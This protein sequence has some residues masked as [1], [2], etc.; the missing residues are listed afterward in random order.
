[1]CGD[2]VVNKT[3]DY[4]SEIENKIDELHKLYTDVSITNI[5]NLL[6]VINNLIF[7]SLNIPNSKPSIYL[8]IA[9]LL[10]SPIGIYCLVNNKQ[11][12]KE[13]YNKI[14]NNYLEIVKYKD[15]NPEYLKSIQPLIQ[16]LDSVCNK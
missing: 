9:K 4:L 13:I 6:F 16:I 3:F 14:K 10:T 11:E 7:Y 2:M 12:V 5:E 8:T 1:M 15:P